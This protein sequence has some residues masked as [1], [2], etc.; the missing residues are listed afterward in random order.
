VNREP[1]QWPKWL[2]ALLGAWGISGLIIIISVPL[3]RILGE[4]LLIAIERLMG[5]VLVAIAIQML[6]TGIAEFIL[7]I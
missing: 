7:S 6:M 5:M 1:T 4:K 3:S 2:A